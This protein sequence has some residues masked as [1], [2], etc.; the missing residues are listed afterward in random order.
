MSK[1]GLL[2]EMMMKDKPQ[3]NAINNESNL[4]ADTLSDLPVADQQAE[5]TKGG[6]DFNRDGFIDIVAVYG[7]H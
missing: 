1:T 7:A 3:G 4:Q 2:K 6:P 5:E